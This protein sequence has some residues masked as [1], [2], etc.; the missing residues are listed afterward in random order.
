[1]EKVAQAVGTR[2][3]YV[4]GIESGKLRPPSPKYVRRFARFYM[5]DEKDLLRHAYAEKAPKLIRD[6]VIRAL[7]MVNPSEQ[8]MSDPG[9]EAS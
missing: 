3:G 5:V 9:P 8:E 4:S 6:E 7:C 1:M 2:K